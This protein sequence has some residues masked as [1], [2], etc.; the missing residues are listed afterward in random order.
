[1]YFTSNVVTPMYMRELKYYIDVKVDDNTKK[2][3]EDTHANSS[4]KHGKIFNPLDGDVLTLKVPFKWRRPLLT[5]D[6]L[7]TIYEYDIGDVL[8]GYAEYNGVWNTI[9]ACGMTWTL[10]AIKDFNS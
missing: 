6:G 7:K 3:I 1:M 5:V 4:V 2:T 10:M 8:C 9:H